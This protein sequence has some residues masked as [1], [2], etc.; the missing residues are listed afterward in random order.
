MHEKG[1]VQDRAAVVTGVAG[2]RGI[3]YAAARV[4]GREG[5]NLAIMDISDEV[6]QRARE[7]NDLGY[8]VTPYKVDLTKL[9]D[10]TSIIQDV[11]KRFGGIHILVNVAGL[12]PRGDLE[13]VKDL[14]DVTE[15]EWDR[16]IDINLKTTYNCVKAVLPI[17]IAQKYGKIVNTSSV[18][19]TVTGIAG[20]TPYAAAKGGILGLTKSLALETAKYNITVNA[21][22]PGWI[23]TGSST[24]AEILAGKA[25]P[26][27][28]P[29]EPEE[30]ADLILFLASDESRYIT[31]QLVVIDG[32][33]TIQEYKYEML[34]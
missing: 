28:R 3:G 17:M 6:N 12:A 10:V 16:S 13:V 21:V 5:A 7:L 9:R 2:P 29:G 25:T 27:G 33:N 20:A 18:T 31:G 24:E 32:G 8:T 26:M 1:R 14:V 11:A 15:E 34:V 22:G 23:H 4:L 19:G 30:V